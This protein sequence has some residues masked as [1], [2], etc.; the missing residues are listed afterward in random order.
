VGA[1]KDKASKGITIDDPKIPEGEKAYSGDNSSSVDAYL[2]VT[3]DSEIAKIQY[4]VFNGGTT[5][6]TSEPLAVDTTKADAKVRLKLKFAQG[7]N[8]ISI[9]NA[10]KRGDG[11][12][13]TIDIDCEHN[14]ASD[15]NVATIVT[16]SQNTRVIVGIEQAGAAS[17]DSKT[18]PFLDLYFTTPFHFGKNKE[19]SRLGLWGNIRLASTPDQ[20]TATGILPSNLINQ[21]GQSSSTTDL[22]QSFDFLAGIE[23]RVKSADNS[24]L[25]LIPGVRQRTHFYLAAGFGAI[26]PLTAKKELAEIFELPKK[27]SPQYDAFVQR[28]GTPDSSKEFIGFVPLDRDRFLRQWYAGFRFKTLYCEDRACN[29][30]LNRFPAIVDFMFGQSEAV[31]GGRLKYDVTTLDPATNTQ[32][33]IGQKNAYVFRLDAFYPLPI[34]EASFIYLYGTAIMK[35]G[36]GG[37]RIENPIFLNRASGG[38]QITDPKVFIP[39]PE[40]QQLLQPNRDYY[41][42]GV[43]LNLTDLF[44]RRKSPQ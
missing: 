19:L 1:G 34:R 12:L 37:V 38:I 15:L 44:N 39:P 3:K 20:I 31:T 16:S 24:Y 33:I 25:G 21:V 42:I 26:S 29:R 7:L 13:T 36:G 14:C 22:V 10:E 27:G 2:T 43:G 28:Y 8:T 23:G 30:Y 35:V 32:K 41:K 40:F 4:D 17:T 9:F 11:N 5:I 6:F 18:K